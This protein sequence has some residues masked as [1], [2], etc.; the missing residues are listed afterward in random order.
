MPLLGACGNE[1][2]EAVKALIE[3]DPEYTENWAP[4]VGVSLPALSVKDTKGTSVDFDDLAGERGLLIF[5]VRST[6]W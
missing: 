1:Y 4:S 3:W 6:N 2:V 5:F